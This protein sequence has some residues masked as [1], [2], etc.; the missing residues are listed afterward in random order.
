MFEFVVNIINTLGV[1]TSSVIG[2]ISAVLLVYA[3]RL[4]LRAARLSAGSSQ[5]TVVRL[6]LSGSTP[7]NL[8][9]RNLDFT[10]REELLTSLHDA[11]QSNQA[12]SLT[13]AVAGL[14]GVGKTELALEYAHRF[15]GDYGLVWWLRAETPESLMTSFVELAPYLGLEADGQDETAQRNQIKTLLAQRKDWLLV[16]DNAEK[17]SDLNDF[18]PGGEGHVLITTRRQT[19]DS[20]HPFPIDVMTEDEAVKL[21]LKGKPN[22]DKE[23][24]L[25]LAQ[26]LGC[27]PLALSHA[28]AYTGEAKID[29][30]AYRQLLAN[31]GPK[32]LA[33]QVANKGTYEKTVATTW[34]ISMEKLSE[35]AKALLTFLSF[36]APEEI[37]LDMIK[38]HGEHLPSSLNEA[39]SDGLRC[40]E[41][42]RELRCYSLVSRE[43]G[44]EGE[45]NLSLHRLVQEVTRHS[46]EEDKFDHWLTTSI[47][48]LKEALPWFPHN[49][50]D[51]EVA[52]GVDRLQNHCLTAAEMGKKNQCALEETS[53]LFTNIGFYRWMRADNR[54]AESLYKTALEVGEKALGEDH[55][56][57]AIGL[58]NL[59]QLYQDTNRL[60][61]A[62][63]LMERALEVDKKAFGDDHPNVARDLN[64]LAGLYEATNRLDKAEPLY[65]R[66]VII[67]VASLGED[68]PNT[69]T[70]INNLAGL[71]AE[72]AAR[73]K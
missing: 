14:G 38:D 18:L 1:F 63:P 20:A 50:Y 53:T 12:T 73:G 39:L 49:T 24:A 45:E 40:T 36:M 47:K 5:T 27:L 60:V 68:H 21:L 28:I 54:G 22:E 66:A 48:I 34:A 51:R 2:L 17:P 32:L 3:G 46:L 19:W 42:I 8:P 37:P 70:V 71:R 35:D 41:M 30:V 15:G 61:K 9:P 52:K 4:G 31:S 56:G 16:F 64:N 13:Q 6:P 62:E 67:F 58:S 59:A 57:V 72:M 25:A 69:Q 23:T 11:L 65:E 7:N 29:F 26:D 55:P 33:K 44:R 43:E 10:G